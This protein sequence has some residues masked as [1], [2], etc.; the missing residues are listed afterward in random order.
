MK[1]VLAPINPTVADLEGNAA[2]V[3]AAIADA[4]STAS[5]LLVFPELAIT[6]YPPRDLFFQRGFV[7][8][9]RDTVLHLTADVPPGL[10]VVLGTPWRPPPDADPHRE[11]AAYDERAR[12]TNALVA[13]RHDGLVARHDKRLLPD[14][15]VFDEPRY[16][17]PGRHAC[18]IDIAGVPT[19]LAVCEDFWKGDDTR[20]GNRY[21]GLPDPIAELTAAGAKLVVLASASPF[22]EGKSTRQSRL[23]AETSARLGVAVAAVNA[24]GAN[25]DLM[26]DGHA[27]MYVPPTWDAIATRLGHEPDREDRAP[28]HDALEQASVVAV[29][30]PFDTEPLRVE[31]PASLERWPAMPA[32]DDPYL[33]A[34][35][36]R[37]LFDALVTG[38]RDYSRKTGMTAAALGVS[39]GIDSA[40]CATLAAAAIGGDNVLG[41]MLPS[42]Y[43]SRHARDDAV[44]LADR[45]NMPLTSYDIEPAHD[46]LGDTLR[47]LFDELGLPPDPGVTEEN[48][49]SRIR[50]LAMMAVSNKSGRLLITTGNKSEHAVG[51]ATL[52]GDQNGGLAP[53]ADVLKTQCYRLARYINEHS[54]E[55][56]FARPPIPENTIAKAPSAELRPNQTDQDSLPPYEDL[57]RVIELYVDE[58]EP[59][60]AI[61]QRTGLD[62]TLVRELVRKI[63]L[64]EYK[65]FQLCV[66]LKV[67]PRAFGPGR[68]WP[69]VAAPA[70]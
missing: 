44:D 15:D 3:R 45:L 13:L 2:R 46:T 53:I 11:P 62:L 34:D 19:G 18:V 63:D 29:S 58:R 10:T 47:A 57:D 21:R 48:I 28:S 30:P 49:Q 56:G 61:A 23:L 66:A 14:Y 4:A 25:D 40:L 54:R 27:A 33:A 32:L 37:L 31:L 55:L 8:R 67:R 26:F 43:S 16:F 39:G 68:R 70:G 42:R 65:R 35:T 41:V 51:Y 36:E 38:I 6:A 7:E 69:I 52:Y 1:V 12:I 24:F 5:D 59:P 17:R 9:C 64:A 50:G 22:I 60:A 20:Y